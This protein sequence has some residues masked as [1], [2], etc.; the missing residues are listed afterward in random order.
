MVDL[1]DFPCSIWNGI[2]DILGDKRPVIVVGNKVDLLP[3]DSKG[4][5]N[6]IR[7][8]LHQNIID[9]G[10][11]KTNIKHV[12]LI[13]A[14]TGYGVEELITQLHN[15]WGSKGDVYL[16]G[17]TNVGK[18]SLFNTLLHSDYCKVQA[19]DIIQRATTCP[20][21]G[22]TLR[23]LK[24][25]ILRPSDHRLFLRTQRLINDQAQNRGEAQLRRIQ[26][27]ATGKIKHATLIGHIGRTFE[28]K[29]GESPD[30][31]SMTHNS[32]FNPKILTVN[33]KGKEFKESK[34]CYD[35]PGVVQPDQVVI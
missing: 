15:I 5:L 35:T 31:F 4:Y 7:K 14:T 9:C 21:P 32:G 25:P 11:T 3:K 2:A 18:S 34:W 30:Q 17:C 6:H 23:I 22:T 29:E 8:S 28:S 33:E 19:T 12:S 16:L 24:F 27:N 10:F 13:S 26:A 1:L 20:W